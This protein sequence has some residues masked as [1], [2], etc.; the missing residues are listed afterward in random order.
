M[1]ILWVCLVT[2]ALAFA[3]PPPPSACT[4]ETHG[5]FWPQEANANRRAA[6]E[7]M[8]VGEVYLCGVTRKGYVWEPLS[9][10]WDALKTAPPHPK[11]GAK[12]K[13]A[14]RPDAAAEQA[15]AH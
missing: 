8:R 15:S 4:E 7:L 10:T 5:Q 1:R 2:V 11:A 14:T 12:A 6:M 13:P 3:A 9:V